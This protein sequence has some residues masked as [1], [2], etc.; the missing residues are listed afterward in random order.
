MAPKARHFELCVECGLCHPRGDECIENPPLNRFAPREIDH[1][2][3]FIIKGKREQ[4]NLEG[5]RFNITMNATLFEIHVAVGLQIDT[6]GAHGAK[7]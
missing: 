7:G 4:Q 3:R 1:A 5:G 2:H 6:Q